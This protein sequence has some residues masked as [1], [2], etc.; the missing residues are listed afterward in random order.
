MALNHTL[1]LSSLLVLLLSLLS[2]LIIPIPKSKPTTPRVS[3]SK[4]VMASTTTTTAATAEIFG[5]KIEKNPP[6][7][8]LSELGVTSW[9]KWGCPPSKFPWT[10]TATETMYLLE[11]KVIVYV[12]GREGSFEIGTGDLVVFPKGMKITWDV[13]EAVNKHYSL[14]K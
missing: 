3:K 1:V 7:S 6:Q 11:G 10:F 12:D 4:P 9:P 5:V 8:K 14:E 2:P 13:I